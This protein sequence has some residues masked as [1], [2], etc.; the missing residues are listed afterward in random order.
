[1][2]ALAAFPTRRSSDLAGDRRSRMKPRRLVV[3][4]DDFGAGPEVNAGVIRAHRDGILTSTS[5][6]VT[7]EAM[8]EAVALAREHPGLA[9]GLRS[10]EHTSELQSRVDV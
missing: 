8:S 3:S 6:M 2:A 7:G 5:L 10:E 1:A 4:G 9:V